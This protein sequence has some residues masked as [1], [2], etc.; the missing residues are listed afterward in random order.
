MSDTQF[1]P[2]DNAPK[3]SSGMQTTML[4]M[5]L[6]MQQPAHRSSSHPWA[7]EQRWAQVCNH[8]FLKA[9]HPHNQANKF[10]S[11]CEW[12]RKAELS[13]QRAANAMGVVFH[14]TSAEW[15]TWRRATHRQTRGAR[16]ATN[17]TIP[18]ANTLAHEWRACARA[19]ILSPCKQKGAI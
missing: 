7:K 6:E 10:H 15:N 17:A 16:R 4:G 18:I 13:H 14:P 5:L 11:C 19:R 2:T 8:A 9:V 3:V 1:Q 12:D